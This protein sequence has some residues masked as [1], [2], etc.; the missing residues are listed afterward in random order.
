MSSVAYL[1]VTFNKNLT[2][3][4]GTL[5][6]LQ[7]RFFITV[8]ADPSFNPIS[9]EIINNR[10]RLGI[11]NEKIPQPDKSIKIEYS[12]TFPDEVN[13]ALVDSST[14]YV[15]TSLTTVRT[16]DKTEIKASSVGVTRPKII[17]AVVEHEAPKEIIIKFTSGRDVSSNSIKGGIASLPSQTGTAGYGITPRFVLGNEGAYSTPNWVDNSNNTDFEGGKFATLK[18]TDL[19]GIQNG[20]TVSLDI[21]GFNI[22]D[23]FDLSMNKNNETTTF[24]VTN[25]VKRLEVDKAYISNIDPS[26]VIIYFKV[27]D[28]SGVNMANIDLTNT[29]RYKVFMDASGSNALY[30]VSGV[31]SISFNESKCNERGIPSEYKDVIGIRYELRSFPFKYNNGGNNNIKIM[32]NLNTGENGNVRIKDVF[33]NKCF[34][35]YYDPRAVQTPGTTDLSC[36]PITTNMIKGI[37]INPQ[38]LD[39]SGGV[40]D[41]SYNVILNFQTNGSYEDISGSIVGTPSLTDFSFNNITTGKIF[42]PDVV[43]QLDSSRVRLVVNYNNLD[44]D[45]M[46]TQG[47]EARLSYINTSW[48]S[49]IKDQYGNFMLAQ[50]DITVTNSLDGSGNVRADGMELRKTA[51]GDWNE[52][53]ISYNVD[54][55]LNCIDASNNIYNPDLSGGFTLSV[56]DPT[57]VEITEIFRVNDNKATI[58]LNK[59]FYATSFPTLTYSNTNSVSRN[60]WGPK[61]KNDNSLT[62]KLI[63]SLSVIEAPRQ[64]FIYNSGKINELGIIDISFTEQIIELGNKEGFKY[65]VGYSNSIPDISTNGFIA[66]DPSNVELV[67]GRIRLHTAFNGSGGIDVSGGI[68]GFSKQHTSSP[69]HIKVKYGITDLSS[70]RPEGGTGYLPN[71]TSLLMGDTSN[72]IFDPSCNLSPPVNEP[73]AIIR[74]DY[75]NVVYVTIQQPVYDDSGDYLDSVADLSFSF[76][77]ISSINLIDNSYN[78]Q[79]NYLTDISSTKV[80]YEE[81]TSL[82]RIEFPVDLSKNDLS[83]NYIDISGIRDQNGGILRSFTDLDIR[84]NVL[85]CD[86]SGGDSNTWTEGTEGFEA[87]YPFIH[88]D[89]GN[90]VY[91]RWNPDFTDFEGTSLDSYYVNGSGQDVECVYQEAEQKSG[92]ENVLKLTFDTNLYGLTNPLLVYKKP[93]GKAGLRLGLQKKWIRDFTNNVLSNEGNPIMTIT[94]TADSGVVNDGDSTGDSSLNLIFTSTLPTTDFIVTDISSNG[95]ISNFNKVDDKIYTATFTPHVSACT[96][97][98]LAGTYTSTFIK[99][100]RTNIAATQF[101]WTQDTTPSPSLKEFT[102]SNSNSSW[103]K[104]GETLT[105]TVLSNHHTTSVNG[106][107]WASGMYL[108]GG[109]FDYS[110][111]D[112]L[113]TI[114]HVMT[115]GDAEGGPIWSQFTAVDQAGNYGSGDGSSSITF[116]KT[117]PT[118]M[119]GEGNT[120]VTS[121]DPSNIRLKFSETLGAASLNAIDFQVDVTLPST[122]WIDITGTDIAI[123]G[124]YVD[125]SL[126]WQGSDPNAYSW[127][128]R[129]DYSKP[130]TGTNNKVIDEAGN[131]VESFGYVDVWTNLNTNT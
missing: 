103:I 106:Q 71:F 97:D 113:W 104:T 87:G 127:D 86:V 48:P 18:L 74:P 129:V 73:V 120:E 44:F 20:M 15:I 19:S 55:C 47:D 17:S 58:K 116:D 60:A 40:Y 50:P 76:Q 39:V 13:G 31:K 33:D 66:V 96:I 126:N 108:F 29:T 119:I 35:S 68:L 53:D 6:N 26:A 46:I 25:N 91:C 78:T 16:Q 109:D 93:L 59:G 111:A 107:V 28:S 62:S 72:N 38:K 63:N 64:V 43:E 51:G 5:Y 54:I 56:A 24:N 45:K 65:S 49:S 102:T 77:D 88:G 41:L 89:A 112:N 80:S 27:G 117:A 4:E 84:S 22:V 42:Y 125:I 32:F 70:N 95:T 23:Q 82:L 115:S 130:L 2:L 101:N 61:L 110:A 123:N 94:A 11:S 1:D 85:W 69:H 9:A 57:G 34:N 98:V 3:K 100:G 36:I 99:G 37:K 79:F 52:I 75:P 81:G 83:L 131:E 118:L 21:S 7:Q 90:V 30:D 128:I 122:D 67:D 14:G 8:G 105:V 12:S 92:G 10:V 124:E 121:S 114:S